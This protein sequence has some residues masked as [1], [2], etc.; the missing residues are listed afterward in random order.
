MIGDCE[1]NY[2]L[3]CLHKLQT[4]LQ[5]LKIDIIKK[6]EEIMETIKIKYFSDKIDKLEYIG[7]KSDWIDL[8]ARN[9]Y[10]K[11]L[12]ITLHSKL[13]ESSFDK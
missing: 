7:G 9:A 11:F 13:P 5:S 10:F 2:M 12:F 3:C 1:T 6:L 8:R 4:V